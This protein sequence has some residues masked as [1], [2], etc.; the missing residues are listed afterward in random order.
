LRGNVNRFDRREAPFDEK[1]H[2]SL[3]AQ[4]GQRVPG[5]CGIAAG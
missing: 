1:L 4:A 5:A 2:F 3:I